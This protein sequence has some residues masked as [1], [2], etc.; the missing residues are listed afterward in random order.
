M[1]AEARKDP[2]YAV[3]RQIP[4]LGPVRISLLLATIKPPW[5]FRTKRNLGAYAGLAVVTG[6]VPGL[7]NRSHR[8][9]AR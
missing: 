7:D 9:P 8:T 6:V 3:L 2:A 1:V 5:C 4:F